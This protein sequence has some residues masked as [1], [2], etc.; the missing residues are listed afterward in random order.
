VPDTN[1]WD[2]FL[3]E[4]DK[5][6]AA[7][8]G[9]GQPMGLGA[10]LALLLIDATYLFIGDSTLSEEESLRI[11]RNSCGQAGWD[12]VGAMAKLAGRARSKGIPVIYT[13]P[14][15]VRKDGLNRGR[16]LDKNRRGREDTAPAP[17]ARDF[18]D[19]IAPTAQDIVIEKEKPSAF[20]GTPLTSYLTDWK[21]DSLLMCGGVTSGCIRSSVL[22][23]FSYN[24]RVGVVREGTFDRI[25]ASHWM[26]LFDMDQKY[27]DV[28]GLD[29]ALAYLDKAEYGPFPA[30]GGGDRG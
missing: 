11:Y 14:V 22:D 26:N 20:F 25:E 24:Y 13:R 16:W 6:I 15:A 10:R 7:Q 29:E 4:H 27:A 17:R 18:A 8:A 9:Y 30:L 2:A 1:G 3:T 12:A 23:G 5:A 28:V 21:I 19:E